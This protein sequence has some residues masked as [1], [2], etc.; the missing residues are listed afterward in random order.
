MIHEYTEIWRKDELIHRYSGFQSPNEI[1]TFI[2]LNK[3]RGRIH[4]IC[5]ICDEE[6]C[7]E[8]AQYFFNNGKRTG[9]VFPFRHHIT[10]D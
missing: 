8:W 1:L 9:A 4:V 3:I 5:K 7:T 2:K 6:N 10:V